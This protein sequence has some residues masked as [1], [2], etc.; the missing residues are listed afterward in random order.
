MDGFE[1][2]TSDGRAEGHK[3]LK[4]FLGVTTFA[5]R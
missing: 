5:Y 2:G 1:A 4:A 3:T